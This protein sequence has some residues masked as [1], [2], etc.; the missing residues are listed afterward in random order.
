MYFLGVV[1]FCTT[2]C[3]FL[4]KNEKSKNKVEKDKEEEITLS[5]TDEIKKKI[6]RLT[7]IESYKVIWHLLKLASVR[8]L[9]LVLFTFYVITLFNFLKISY[10]K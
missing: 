9:S 2:I 7:L 3:I 5:E 10:L 6:K 8:E 4:F 1:F